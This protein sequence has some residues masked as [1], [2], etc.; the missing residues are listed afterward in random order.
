[1]TDRHSSRRA[2]RRRPDAG[3]TLPELLIS[4]VLMSLIAS[5]IT[6]AIITSIKTAPDVS[7]RADSAIAVQG[8]TTFLPPDVDSTEPGGFD[9]NPG[10][11]SGCTGTDPGQNVVRMQWHETFAGVTTTYVANYR[12]VI[13]GSTGTI[14][15]LSC[16][17]QFSLN[18]PT[19]LSMTAKL[20]TTVPV[21]SLRDGDGDGKTDAFTIEIETFSGDV[22]DIDAASKN[23]AETLPPNVT[24][25]TTTIVSTT[26]APTTTTTT[27]VPG[28]TT[29]VS[30][31]TT[32]TTTTSSTTTSTTLPPCV[33]SNV[34]ATPNPV[35]L[36][37]N[38][39]SKLREDV[40]VTV[41]VTG[42]YCVGLTLQY[43]TGG[44][45]G[46]YVQN[47]GPIAP[48][49]VVLKGHP[50]GTE[51]WTVGPHVLEVRDGY[52]NLLGQTTLTV[53]PK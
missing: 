38:P 53:Q 28:P 14:V 43:D 6:M 34:V 24:N 45:N 2:L 36:K 49:Q 40:T 44:P 51:L 46:Q 52:D 23:P 8:I 1:V 27:T 26:A 19:Q 11:A 18:S 13:D 35:R 39:P 30:G 47:L 41:T 33:V 29:T 7:D 20:S 4:I 17:G 21:V 12:F 5:V 16:S 3:F 15:R 48:Y 25:P 10:T 42:G 37:S 50:Q 31:P 32:T 9:I 22:V